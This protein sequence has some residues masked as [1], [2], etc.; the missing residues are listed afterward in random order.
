MHAQAMDMCRGEAGRLNFTHLV[1]VVLRSV[2]CSRQG[3]G[4]VLVRARHQARHQASSSSLSLMRPPRRSHILTVC[5]IVPGSVWRAGACQVRPC[6]SPKCCQHRTGLLRQA[7]PC[8]GAHADAGD[9]I[10]SWQR[11]VRELECGSAIQVARRDRAHG[12]PMLLSDAHVLGGRGDFDVLQAAGSHPARRLPV[13]KRASERA[14]SKRAG[15]API[16][17]HSLLHAYRHGPGGAGSGSCAGNGAE[18]G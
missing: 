3:Q 2:D 14:I 13:E 16:R 5:F 6:T 1:E 15:V 8:E 10:A 4:P 7:G 18:D 17:K 9:A 11:K 12:R